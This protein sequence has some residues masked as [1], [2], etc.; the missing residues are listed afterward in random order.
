MTRHRPL[1]PPRFDA[2]MLL[3]LAAL[4]P[5]WAGLDP[6][7]RELSESFFRSSWQRAQDELLSRTTR[8]RVVPAPTPW[9]TLFRFELDRPYKRKPWPDGPVELASGPIRGVIVYRPDILTAV[10]DEPSILVLIDPD[11]EFFHPNCNRARSSAVCLGELPPG[12]FEL[13]HLLEHLYGILTYE[14]RTPTHP[15]DLEAAVYFACDPE[16]MEG[17][18]PVEPLY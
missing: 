1:P 5:P 10:G 15:A 16:A 9:P 8:L 6:A 17:L 2:G 3:A 4:E 12:P 14:N 13:T 11:L 7:L 18:L